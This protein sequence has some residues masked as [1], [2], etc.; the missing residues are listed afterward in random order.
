[1]ESEEIS[2]YRRYADGI[3]IIFD[4]SKTNED[5]ITNYLKN[6]HIYFELKITEEENNINYLD[7]SIHTH[8]NNL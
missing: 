3:L 6:I 2:W 4:E 7:F 8:D 5:S 1:M